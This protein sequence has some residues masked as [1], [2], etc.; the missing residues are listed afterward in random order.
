M[1]I[2]VCTV[3]TNQARWQPTSTACTHSVRCVVLIRWSWPAATST[4]AGTGAH[5]V[6]W[7]AAC[8]G[9]K[10][11]TQICTRTSL[12]LYKSFPFVNARGTYPRPHRGGNLFMFLSKVMDRWQRPATMSWDILGI[13]SNQQRRM[14]P[15]VTKATL[16]GLTPLM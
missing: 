8:T 12:S 16:H 7:K 5:V 14:I 15:K 6:V 3:N 9:N 4:T 10:L 11:T 1:L 2:K 13:L